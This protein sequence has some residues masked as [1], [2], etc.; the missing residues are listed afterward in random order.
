VLGA[1]LLASSKLS[2]K[3]LGATRASGIFA[4][5]NS[6]SSPKYVLFTDSTVRFHQFVQGGS[7]LL[8]VEV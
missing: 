2:P 6:A 8:F 7:L 5:P 1:R 4:S 3:Y